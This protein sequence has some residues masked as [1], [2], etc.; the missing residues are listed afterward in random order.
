MLFTSDHGDMLG[1]HGLWCKRLFYE[2]SARVPMI[3]VGAAGD[4]WV[5]HHRTDDRLMG[6]VDVM[7]TLLE[8]AGLEVPC[9]VEGL[10]MVGE[11]RRDW[12]YGEIDEDGSA[13][14]MVHDGRFKLIYYPV[15][16]HSQLFDLREDPQELNNLSGLPSHAEVEGRLTEHL[17]GA[18]HGGDEGWVQ[19]GKLIGLPDRAYQP[20]PNRGLSGQ[21]GLHWP[22]PTLADR[23]R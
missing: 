18:L 3:L 4:E 6:L 7:P 11:H 8:L 13:T 21:R 14:R 9:T 12:L 16:N 20:G 15:G 17:V 10:S 19:D 23:V 5:G 1:N 22:A 2:D